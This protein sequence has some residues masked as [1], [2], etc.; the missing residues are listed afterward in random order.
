MHVLLGHC[1]W[2]QAVCFSPDSLYLAS[3]CEDETVKIWGVVEGECVKTLEV[4]LTLIII[5]L[6]V[7]GIREQT[8]ALLVFSLN[9]AELSLNSANSGNLRNH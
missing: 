2:I 1:G 8:V 3:A 6:L 9:R 7:N 4:K 5:D